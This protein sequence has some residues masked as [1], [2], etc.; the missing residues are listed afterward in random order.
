MREIFARDAVEQEEQEEYLDVEGAMRVRAAFARD[1]EEPEAI[2]SWNEEVQQQRGWAIH[3][4]KEDLILR[5][6]DLA[7]LEANFAGE[8]V[9]G[10]W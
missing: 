8:V 10:S 2:H 6:W 7:A 1:E 9:D 3:A 4:P 5:E